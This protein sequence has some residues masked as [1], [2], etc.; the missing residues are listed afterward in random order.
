MYLTQSLHRVVQQSPAAV[1]CRFADRTSTYSQL[2]ERVA[3]LAAAL[4]GL[5]VKPGDRV[6]MLALNSDRYLEYYLA[7]WWAGAVVNP[8][9]V[10]WSAKEVAFSLQ[11][12]DTQV[13]LV[14][15][16]FTALVPELRKLVPE[17][18]EVILL[19]DSDSVPKDV[20]GAHCFEKLIAES[21]PVEDLRVGGD[22]L[23]AIFYTGGTTGQP[24][25][26][27]LSHANLWVS[28][29]ARMAQVYSSAGSTAIHVAPLYHL[30]SAG[31][32]I[33]Q[34]IHG[35]ESVILP[36]F[37]PAAL[38]AG[39]ERH[40]VQEITLVPSMI[41]MLLN[42]PAFDAARLA[43]L[44]RISYGASPISEVTLDRAQELLPSV[45]FC[46]S[47]GQTEAAPIITIN[48]PENHV[49]EGRRL[50]RMR[51]AGRACYAVEVRIEDPEGREVQRGVV[52]EI[53][54]RGPNVMLGYWNRP[55]ETAQALRGGWLH[56]G[57]GGYMDEA[58]YVFIVDRLK[59]MIVTGG[60]NVYSAEVENAV[61]QHSAVADCAVF[62]IPSERWGESVHVAVV[63]K[64]GAVLDLE[65]LQAHCR[66]LIASYKVPRG[67]DV[68]AALPLSA[69]GKVLKT[70]LRQPHW[71]GSGRSVH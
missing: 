6:A 39:I 63:L 22:T 45:E 34:L 9:N 37:Q 64:P 59:D 55:E 15:D 4:I 41:Q 48:P 7:T 18:R 21:H 35:G 36:S 2:K 16:G 5:G 42:D 65:Q 29:L 8:V 10:R 28:G 54:A 50:G 68:R 67:M 31:R 13:L 62:G 32:L 38:I 60:E 57:D 49:G 25:G 24:K 58:G 53:C 1:A 3:R 44:R 33:T 27:M 61:R 19:S 40:R 70:E 66:S 20:A 51:A 71:S 46:Q 26:V 56:T 23:A 17:L 11:D 30:A 69:V 52:G 43:S 12:C 14:D 47:Y